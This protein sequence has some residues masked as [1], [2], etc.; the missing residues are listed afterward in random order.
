MS[1]LLSHNPKLVVVTE[2]KGGSAKKPKMPYVCD[3][4]DLRCIDVLQFIRDQKWQF[5]IGTSL[6]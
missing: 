3:Q 2:E 4:E 6:D 5:Q 1:S